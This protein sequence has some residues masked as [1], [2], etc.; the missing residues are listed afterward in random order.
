MKTVSRLF[1]AVFVFV[2][3]G[4]GGL[5]SQISS[6]YPKVTVAWPSLNRSIEAPTYAKSA[7]ISLTNA[8]TNKVTHWF[9]DR[10]S[11]N[12]QQ[13]LTYTCSETLNTGNGQLHVD[14][15][16]GL[17]G[18]GEIVATAAASIQLDDKG[19]LHNSAGGDL[20][21][22]TYG[23]VLNGLALNI[24][25][26]SI[27]SASPLIFSGY[28]S[29]TLI[30]IPQSLIQVNVTENPQLISIVDRTVTGVAEGL[31]VISASFE[32]VSWQFVVNVI[33]R[34]QTIRTFANL[35]PE[36]IAWDPI[37]GKIWG[38]FGP[39]GAYPNSIVD[40]DPITGNAG[41]PILVGS[42]PGAISVSVDGSTAYVGID[43]AA[44]VRKV[45]LVNRVALTT[46]NLT[47][48]SQ[49]GIASHIAINPSDANEVAV[50]V[51]SQNS[52]GFAGPFVFRNGVQVGADPGIYTASSVLYTSSTTL[53]GIQSGI[54]SGNVYRFS[55][56]S[57]SVDTV[58][59]VTTGTYLGTEISLSGQ[60]F[61]VDNG[62]VFDSSN[63]SQLGTV[64]YPSANTMSS[65][66]GGAHNIVWAFFQDPTPFHTRVNL[67]AFNLSTFVPVDASSISTN[68]IKDLKLWGSSGMAICTGDSLMIVDTL[69][70]L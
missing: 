61:V 46:I 41:T 43:G 2:L 24:S 20:G 63:L 22:I 14:F 38:T 54:S 59:T 33:P 23:T 4:C 39:N 3:L 5:G 32:S 50:C 16:S 7:D 6:S 60:N 44:A 56:S 48:L 29:N 68:Q 35:N 30:A 17:G 1:F 36:K 40:I 27:G 51:G 11:G 15:Y 67:R 49:P 10:P 53:V 58:Q 45:D 18:S 57:N 52:G 70:G 13:T 64:T 69:P 47:L 21:T 55:V 28:V 65:V 25:E 34:Q 42:S 19:I 12:E 8:V 62:F 66:A 9:V 31:T 26:L 37:H